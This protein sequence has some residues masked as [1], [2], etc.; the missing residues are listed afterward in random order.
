MKKGIFSTWFR[1]IATIIFTQTI[2]AFL[3]AIVMSIIISALGKTTGT[4]DQSGSTA[5]A[6]L[7]AIIALSQFG[8]FE[9]LIKSIFGVTSGVADTSMNAGYRGLT[10]GK[11]IAA[12][13]FGK[14]LDNGRKIG[15]GIKAIK[16]TSDLKN[17]K[18]EKEALEKEQDYGA[19]GGSTTTNRL[20]KPEDKVETLSVSNSDILAAIREQTEHIDKQTQEQLRSRNDDKIEKLQQKIEET[21]NK[22]HE[23]IKTGASGAVE[24]ITGAYGAAAGLSVGLAQG[25]NIVETTFAGMGVGDTVGQGMVN[26]TDA[27]AFKAPKA[28]KGMAKNPAKRNKMVEDA[29]LKQEES[30]RKALD[31]IDKEIAKATDENMKNMLMQQ[32]NE[33]TQKYNNY[34]EQMTSRP[35]ILKDVNKNKNVR[36]AANKALKNNSNLAK[37][38]V[39]YDIGKDS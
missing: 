28:I 7:L 23:Q 11:M 8:K 14:V 4:T 21:S 25:D 1:E 22:R 19:T 32:S 18:A 5:A 37:K 26:A 34:V 24:T 16:T 31:Q 10:A 20:N 27:V 15:Q 2:Q 29:M 12:R 30:A 6:G 17:L 38:N 9:M 35:N 33:V 36:G 3:L 39:R 13:G